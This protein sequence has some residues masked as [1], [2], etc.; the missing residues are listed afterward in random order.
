MRIMS[1]Q[2]ACLAMCAFAGILT[3]PAL[4]VDVARMEQV[5]QA[6]AVDNK[7]MGAVLVAQ[8]DTI[9][10]DKGYGFANLEWNIPNTPGTRFRIGSLT[11][12]F[13]AAAVLLLEERGKLKLDNPV[14][15][16]YP[17]APAGWDRI[18][19]FNLLTQTSGIP[20]YTDAPDFGDTMK[21][22]RTPQ[23]LIAAVR[24][25]TLDFA[26]G[27]KFAY[28]N[29]NYVL[30][31][32]IIEKTS[33]VSYQKFVQ[34][35]IFTPLG[36]KDSGFDSAALMERRASPYSRRNGA[37]VNA[38]YVDPS[39]QVGGGAIC[40]TTHD[41]LIWEKAILDGKL[42]SPASTKKMFT[43]FRDARGPGAPYKAGYGM[44]VYVGTTMDGHR[45]IAH[46]GS[47]SGV[48]T[49]MAAYPDD[50][51]F[52]ILLSN[53]AT[54]PFA[55]IVSKLADLGRDKT[56]ILPSE[57]KS[58][59][60]N[61]KLMSGYAGRYQ[62]RPGFVIEIA[63][64]GDALVAHPGDNPAIALLP[65]SISAFYAMNP[66]LQVEF[67]TAHGRVTS[68]VWHINGDILDAPR[69]P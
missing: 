18:T 19:L 56:I 66:D 61:A 28:S 59:A 5:L 52:V 24:D 36:M 2:I 44:G 45:E 46:T 63:R 49:M 11:K 27:E 21:L 51:L 33:G 40:S 10:L 62:L 48:V 47:S 32:Q 65:E 17:D 30:L 43:P 8:G 42:L 25:K 34:D 35:N 68:L 1:R 58:I 37:I 6:A 55:D 50:R 41:L 31:S 53:S 60:F 15:A 57:R 26:P 12:Q 39:V 20:D 22:Q 16:Y 13:A 9:L 29:S 4:A 23:Q 38:S 7:F 69:L 54:T 64:E 3:T 67:R 14:K